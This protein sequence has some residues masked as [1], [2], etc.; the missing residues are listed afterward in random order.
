M[1]LT[2]TNKYQSPISNDINILCAVNVFIL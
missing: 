1:D 2:I